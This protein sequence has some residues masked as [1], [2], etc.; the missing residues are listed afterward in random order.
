MNMHEDSSP[1]PYVYQHCQ[2]SVAIFR[3]PLT[4]LKL[5]NVEKKIHQF[6]RDVIDD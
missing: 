6:K 5:I 3:L 1:V 4:V 2:C